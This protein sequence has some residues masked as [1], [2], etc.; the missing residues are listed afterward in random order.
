MGLYC[1]WGIQLQM[2]SSARQLFS[3]VCF[4]LRGP[5][6]DVGTIANNL[7]VRECPAACSGVR[8]TGTCVILT[9]GK[10]NTQ[11]CRHG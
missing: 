11:P 9:L 2:V 8:A 5:E 10:G 7:K 4:Q 6:A 3:C 1:A